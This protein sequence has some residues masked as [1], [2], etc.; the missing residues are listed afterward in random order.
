MNEIKEVCGYFMHSSFPQ[1][2]KS[3]IVVVVTHCLVCR[4]VVSFGD[5]I[6]FIWFVL[7]ETKD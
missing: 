1:T 7:T 2:S 5:F 4:E 3:T 6:Y